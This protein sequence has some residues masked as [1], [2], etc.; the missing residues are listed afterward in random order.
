MC[1]VGFWGLGLCGFG[2]GCCGRG[3]VL[4]CRVLISYNFEKQLC[5]LDLRCKIS[6]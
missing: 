4:C 6:G 5:A 1:V 2:Q 3:Q